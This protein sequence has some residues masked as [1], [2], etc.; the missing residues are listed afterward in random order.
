MSKFPRA[1]ANSIPA[2]GQEPCMEYVDF[3]K[4]GIGARSSGMPKGGEAPGGIR[5]LDHVGGSAGSKK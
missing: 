1:Y 3:K 5:G 2:E 4:L